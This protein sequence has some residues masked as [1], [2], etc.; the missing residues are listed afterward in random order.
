MRTLDQQFGYHI[1]TSSCDKGPPHRA[2][3]AWFTP[4]WGNL[5]WWRMTNPQEKCK[6]YCAVHLWIV[7]VVCNAQENTKR[8]LNSQFDCYVR[9]YEFVF[10]SVLHIFTSV[11][12]QRCSVTKCHE[13]IPHH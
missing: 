11:D 3:E 9:M 7:C 8:L 5:L 1:V 12:A 10:L 13:P 4:P 6:P 2:P